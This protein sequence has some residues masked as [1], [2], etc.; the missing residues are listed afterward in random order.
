MSIGSCFWSISLNSTK[1]GYFIEYNHH[2]EFHLTG[3]GLEEVR[4]KKFDILITSSFTAGAITKKLQNNLVEDL[5]GICKSCLDHN[6]SAIIVSD[7][8]NR[9]F[10]YMSLLEDLISE[11]Q[12]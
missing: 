4:D 5:M 1:I 3:F 10:E 6:K 8:Y 11:N 12:F 7:T 2:S 9:I